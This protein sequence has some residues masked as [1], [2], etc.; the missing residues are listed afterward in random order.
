MERRKFLKGAGIVGSLVGGVVAGK[1]IVEKHYYETK[2]I[3]PPEQPKE[4]IS[5]LAPES[6]TR[7]VLQGGI[8]NQTLPQNSSEFFISNSNVEYK[9]KVELSVG[10]DNHL[11]IKVGEEWKRVVVES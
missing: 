1:T 10:K 7:L 2:Y 5:H 3:P 11:W 6:P 4:D 9:N 8:K